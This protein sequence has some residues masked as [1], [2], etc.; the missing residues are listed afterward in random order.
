M[1]DTSIGEHAAAVE[2]GRDGTRILVWDAP[3][4]VV[5]W[6][7]A[8][9]FAGAYLTAESAQWR[10]AHVILGYTVAGLACFRVLWGVVGSRYARFTSFVRGP[11]AIAAYLGSLLRGQPQHFVGHNPAGALTVIVLLFL[12]LAVGVSGWATYTPAGGATY[13]DVHNV[14]ANLMLIVVGI[15]IVGALVSSW[16][17]RENLVAAMITGFKRGAPADAIVKRWRAVGALLLA[18]VLGFWWWQWQHPAAGVAHPERA[19]AEP[20]G[21]GDAGH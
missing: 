5:H 12:A 2:P 4:R 13:E 15:H 6:V 20:G 18:V 16:L 21:D 3:V 8:A 14:L 7:L 10:L 11:R 9:S 1:N 17:H 19:A